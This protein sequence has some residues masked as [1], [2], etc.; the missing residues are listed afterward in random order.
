MENKMSIL[1]L[2]DMT[3]E[4]KLIAMEELWEDISKNVDNDTIIPKWHLDVLEERETRLQN[5]QVQ[6]EDFDKVK[7]ELDE[8]FNK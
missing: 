4:Q 1:N 6:F 5:G 3:T 7:K 8:K 2:Q